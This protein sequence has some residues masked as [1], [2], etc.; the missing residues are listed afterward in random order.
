M[1][2]PAISSDDDEFDSA[3]EDEEPLE[4]HDASPSSVHLLHESAVEE[5]TKQHMVEKLELSAAHNRDLEEA[6]EGAAEVVARAAAAHSA[7]MVDMEVV[8]EAALADLKK[9]QQMLAVMHEEA[10]E[11]YD[12]MLTQ[13][14]KKHKEQY[15]TEM[16]AWQAK[17]QE[18][19]ELVA[20]EKRQQQT[21]QVELQESRA[22]CA[23][24]QASLAQSERAAAQVRNELQEER[25]QLHSAAVNNRQLANVVEGL[26][27]D[28]EAL[29]AKRSM[30]HAIF[31]KL[32]DGEEDD[33]LET[34]ELDDLVQVHCVYLFAG[35]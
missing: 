18:L 32:G 15:D 5:L 31:A 13:M 28:L 11:N 9:D 26:E 29:S 24:V 3:E 35:S 20:C 7:E 12:M 2:G 10:S 1:R 17:V 4:F 23:A 19:D 33:M 27:K 34:D 25:E 14:Q 21:L 30:A 22:E 6:V 16:A 8:H